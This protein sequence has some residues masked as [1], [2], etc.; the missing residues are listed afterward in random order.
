VRAVHAGDAARTLALLDDP[1]RPALARIDPADHDGLVDALRAG[2]AA[3]ASARSASGR[4]TALDRFRVLCAHRHGPFG[5][6]EH[7]ALVEALLAAQG[8]IEPRPGPYPGRPVL[9]TRNDPSAGLYNGDVGVTGR[10]PGRTGLR[11]LFRSADGGERWLSPLRIGAAETVFAMSVHKAQGS[12]LDAVGVVLPD[13]ASP[14]VTR[15]LL[16]TA[17]SR[18]REAVWIRASA[19]TIRDA[20]ARRV[21]RASGLREAIWGP[22]APVR[23]DG[24]PTR[25]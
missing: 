19:E 1:D 21:E 16:Y 18:A 25:R 10:A 14:V 22:D 13:V 6:A 7:N 20:L 17:V 15:E 24:P 12:E 2:Y 5:V 9:V 23:P 8:A 3:Y 4:L 11:V